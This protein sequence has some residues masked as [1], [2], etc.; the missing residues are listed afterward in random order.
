MTIPAYSSGVIARVHFLV[1][2]FDCSLGDQSALCVGEL[3]DDIIGMNG[4]CGKFIFMPCERGDVNFDGD[5]TPGDAL[6]AFWRSIEGVFREECMNECAE[7]ASDVNCDN[8][9]TPGDALCIFWRSIEGIWREEC[10]CVPEAKAIASAVE[11]SCGAVTGTP[12]EKICIPVIVENAEDLDAF[13]MELTYP[14][15]LLIYEGVLKTVDTEGWI[16]LDGAEIDEGRI[17]LGGF[18]TEGIGLDD[19]TKIAQVTF[20]VRD[21]VSGSGE[22]DLINLVD[23]LAGGDVKKGEIIV[24]GTL[25]KYSL[26]QNYPNPFNPE[27]EIRYEIPRE[28]EVQLVVYNVMG[29]EV[30]TLVNT[31]QS[32]GT[33]VVKW[34]ADEMSSGIYFYRLKINDFTATRRMVLMK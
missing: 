30:V 12:G 24:K 3:R 14:A 5:I 31:H 4:C 25:E 15:D 16:A 32:A 9:V 23:D 18:H 2:C 10:A 8:D 20:S 17:K 11:I 1:S 22:F 34:N 19:P 7:D 27:T 29:Q 28:G 21:G 13:A 26:S 33:H 6:C